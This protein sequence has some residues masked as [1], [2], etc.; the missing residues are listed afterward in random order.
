MNMFKTTICIIFASLTCLQGKSQ[1]T[2][3]DGIRSLFEK[4]GN[5]PA[6]EL[7]SC[8]KISQYKSNIGKI[9]PITLKD[10]LAKFISADS[11]FIK[12]NKKTSCPVSKIVE[13]LD[14][15]LKAIS[16]G[17]INDSLQIL[18]AILYL[19]YGVLDSAFVRLKLSVMA[20]NNTTLRRPVISLNSSQPFVIAPRDAYD[21]LPAEIYIHRGMYYDLTVID[22]GYTVHHEK[23]IAYGDTALTITLNAI[24]NVLGKAPDII[25]EPHNYWRILSLLLA[26][27]LIA[28]IWKILSDKKRRVPTD[29]KV[30]KPANDKQAES[31]R[32]L[33]LEKSIALLNTQ[34]KEKDALIAKYTS[35]IQVVHPGPKETGTRFFL[36]ELMM[37]A[38]PRKKRMSELNADKDLGED[39]CGFILKGDDILTWL[40]DGTSD[41]YCLRNPVTHREYFSSRLL[42]QSI[43]RELKNHFGEGRMEAFDQT[44]TTIINDVKSNWM[45]AISLLPDSEKDVLKNNIKSGNFPEC[46]TTVLIGGLSL[47]W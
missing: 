35:E 19:K 28:S 18:N 42:A 5:I 34:L 7:G 6:D 20:A 21:S 36:S 12:S 44:M 16:A 29:E 2:A 33:K 13:G 3:A 23:V 14:T 41:F 32:V 37:T 17:D 38:G 4:I 39:V 31:E 30:Y 24:E 45:K 22:S 43:A 11:Q 8:T 40:L 10:A 26:L 25:Q 9:D 46:A 27:G 1:K 47:K 15:M